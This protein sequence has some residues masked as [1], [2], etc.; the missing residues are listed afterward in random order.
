MNTHHT[1]FICERKQS[2]LCVVSH[3]KILITNWIQ[4]KI[5]ILVT[6][7]PIRITHDPDLILTEKHADASC[8]KLFFSFTFPPQLITACLDLI[9]TILI[10]TT[11]LIIT[12]KKTDN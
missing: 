8:N 5:Y 9:I 6:H 2:L 7:D 3:S 10:I 4:F 1:C 11:V 12:T